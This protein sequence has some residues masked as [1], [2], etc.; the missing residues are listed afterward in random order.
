MLTF[1]WLTGWLPV[2]VHLHH[3]Q[4]FLFAFEV[5]FVFARRNS[6]FAQLQ[7]LFNFDEAPNRIIEVQ[8]TAEYTRI[9]HLWGCG[10]GHWLR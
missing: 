7:F 3:F 9:W 6:A 10:W 4:H 5:T 2:V 1:Y 8:S